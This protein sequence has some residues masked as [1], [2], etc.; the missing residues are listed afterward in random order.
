[1]DTEVRR[2][3]REFLVAAGAVGAGMLLT[4][5]GSVAAAEEKNAK[6]RSE[7]VVERHTL[8]VRDFGAKGDGK[9][10]DTE[11]IQKA[12][13]SA[14]GTE[15]TV[16]VPEGL[17]LSGEL[18]MSPGVGICGFPVWSYRNSRGAVIRLNDRG[19]KCLLNLTGAYGALV[20]GICL[21]GGQLGGERPIHGI[22]VDKPDYGSQED[23]PRIDGCR[24]E[25][26]TG[27]GIRLERIWCFSVRH[28]HC[29]G[30]GGCGLRVRG[31]DGFIMDNWFSGNG[32]AGFGA[33]DESASNTLTANRIE[34]NR[35]GGIL[36]HGG[37]TY[38][39]TGN[40]IDRSGRSG[41]ALLPRGGSPC[42]VITATGNVIYRSGKSEWGRESDYDS[43]HARFE[44]VRGLVF[45]GNAMTAGR[46]DGN[47]GAWSP[48]Y[49]IVVRRLA[50]SIIKDNVMHEG[51]L[52]ELLVDL[53][54][55]DG[56]T[57]VIKDNVGTLQNIGIPDKWP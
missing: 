2:T 18:R 40:Y 11:A 25:Q 3:R 24:V 31:W 56:E 20:N 29:I 50:S 6:E 15:G 10:D 33:Y 46:D 47:K 37:S 51:S 8:N 26:F 41:I 32:M 4:G 27:D 22:M 52:K 44:N 28:S 54:E 16:F 13:D 9:T 30:N 39:I 34:W 17:Y 5:P 14:A 35:L 43:A 7:P 1:M 45:I 48:D 49:S 19:A 12:L 55:H 42:G 38:N 23:T 57:V 36:I 53:G 21:H